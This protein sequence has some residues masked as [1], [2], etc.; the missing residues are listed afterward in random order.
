MSGNHSSQPGLFDTIHDFVVAGISNDLSESQWLEF[1]RL[2][3]EN[4]DACRLYVEYVEQSDL[5]QAIMDATLEEAS[6]SWDAFFLDQPDV[7][8]P[9]APSVPIILTTPVPAMGGYF[10]SGWPVA[11]LVATV[12]FAIGL[13]IGAFTYVSR[14]VEVVQQSTNP[15]SPIPN[16][17][18]K[19]T[20]VGRITGMVECVWESGR[21]SAIGGQQ[22]QSTSHYRLATN[23]SVSLGDRIALKS[24]LLEITYDS[25]AK[26]VLQGP[27][28]YEVESA[29]AGYLSVGKLTARLEKRSA[30]SGQRSVARESDTSSLST[31]HYPLFTITTP[32]A[33]VTDLGT[34]FGVDVD[35]TGRSDVC[36]HS[37]RVAIQGANGS[38]TSP[39]VVLKA[40]EARR[41][42]S[43]DSKSWLAIDAKQTRIA[44]PLT[45]PKAKVNGHGE[46]ELLFSD[47]FETFSLGT[48]WRAIKDGPPNLALGAV[49][50]GSRTV[51]AMQ[52]EAENVQ[53]RGIETIEPIPIEGM[54]ALTV[55]TLFQPR[56]GY[57]PPLE[58]H[59]VGG[60]ATARLIMQP[61]AC[62]PAADVTCRERYQVSLSKTR[63]SNFRYDRFVL[64]LDAKGVTASFLDSVNPKPLWETRFDK[65]TLADFGS[66]VK[67]VLCQVS[68]CKGYPSESHV[69]WVTVR[70][71]RIHRVPREGS[72]PY[73]G[74]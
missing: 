32:T 64:S 2:L 23:H 35:E 14:P 49:I 28:T 7:E 15:Q 47:Q 33:V 59:V 21:R 42:P 40:G 70:G 37:G 73:S 17:S 51:L 60:A 22:L 69:D 13:A 18:P 10:S 43:S 24:G 67:I 25:G 53:C 46:G 30:I 72:E 52:S 65:V 6:S 50:D 20:I 71:R 45:M 41:I 19:A 11:Y 1:E 36:V 12:I 57:N 29:K 16:P 68:Y 4:D 63:G 66:N 48:R 38:A 39:A 34:E 56:Q 5:L 27:V 61:H 31:I 55:S 3:R 26:V 74:K 44:Q 54:E 62:E 9:I 8:E 58:L